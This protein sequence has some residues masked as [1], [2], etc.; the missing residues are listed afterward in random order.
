M[1]DNEDNSTPS[2][3]T[4]AA[5]VPS[6]PARIGGALGISIFSFSFSASL[7]AA[8]LAVRALATLPVTA[9]AALAWDAL[10]QH[11][12]PSLPSSTLTLLHFA[13]TLAVGGGVIATGLGTAT[14]VGFAADTLAGTSVFR[15]WMLGRTVDDRPWRPSD[16]SP[17]TLFLCDVVLAAVQITVGVYALRL[18]DGGAVDDVTGNPLRALACMEVGTAVSGVILRSRAKGWKRG[19]AGGPNV[20]GQSAT[21]GELGVQPEMEGMHKKI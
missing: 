4:S 9:A 18:W 3:N 14:A 7:A 15:G 1:T 8:I 16:I 13:R 6:F 11:A 17:R 20:V 12:A 2:T 21:G 19:D 5:A 10:A